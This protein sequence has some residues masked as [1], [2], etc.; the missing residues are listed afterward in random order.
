MKILR[1]VELYYR[2]R[3]ESINPQLHGSQEGEEITNQAAQLTRSHYFSIFFS[4]ALRM[5]IQQEKKTR[6]LLGIVS[7]TD[8]ELLGQAGS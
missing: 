2:E 7:D 1:Y 5:W 6:L 8:P 3:K 4:S